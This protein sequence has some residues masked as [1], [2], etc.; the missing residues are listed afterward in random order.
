[1]ESAGRVLFSIV[2]IS[3]MFESI[4]RA[5]G[6]V[7]KSFGVLMEEKRLLLFPIISAIAIIAVL[8][9]FLIPVLFVSGNMLIPLLFA[10]YF[11][12]YFVVIFFNSALIHAANEKLESRPVS[13]MGSISF[14]LS[15]V[16]N[17]ALWAAISATVG[18]ILGLVRGASDNGR[19]IGAIIG[20]IVASVIGAAWSIATFFVV[21]VMVFEDVSPLT[22]I[23]R[24]VDMVKKSWSEQMIGGFAIGIVFFIAYMAGVLLIIGGVVVPP[25]IFVLVPLGLSIMLVAFITQGA[26][27]G[28]FLAEL[29]RYS[30]N[31]QSVIFK[32]EIEQ[33]RAMRPPGLQPPKMM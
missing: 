4:T 2:A 23:T 30:K 1:M 8:V 29:Y 3:S 9:S 28:I 32:E 24:S 6:I 11:A 10:F 5:F 33:V 12:S 15:R 14:A 27:E 26:I 18:V 16:L 19:G 17:I 7:K 20:K 22:A 25:L 31:G 13:M 21:P